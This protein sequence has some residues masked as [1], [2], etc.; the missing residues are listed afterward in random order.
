M[1]RPRADFNENWQLAERLVKRARPALLHV[2]R[3]NPHL[4]DEMIKRRCGHLVDRQLDDCLAAQDLL[5]F[6]ASGR[7]SEDSLG[8][9]GQW[10]APES[11]R[12]QP[13]AER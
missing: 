11:V 9:V 6:R 10:R 13:V 1:N 8:P 3:A 7:T 4:S 12:N 2:L 5:Q